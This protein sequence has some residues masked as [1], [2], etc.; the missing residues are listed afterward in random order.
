[1]YEL[2]KCSPI[3]QN[4]QMTSHAVAG[5]AVAFPVRLTSFIGRVSELQDVERALNRHRLVTLAGPGGAG[6]TRLAL[7]V[8]RGRASEQGWFVDLAP[9][10]GDSV[11]AA[12]AV[13]TDAPEAPGESP[14]DATVR[15]IGESSALLMLDNC[16]QVV[17]SCARAVDVLLRSC[18]KLTILATSR[19][20]LRVEGERVWRVP[21]LSL[22]ADG[23]SLD[24]DA[25]LLFLDR[26]RLTTDV[27]IRDSAVIHDICRRLDGMPLAIELA[28]ARASILP[29]ADVFAGLSDR[30]RLLEGGPRTADT[31]QQSLAASIRWSYRLLADDERTVL[32]RLAVYRAPF[33]AD[34]ARAVATG[35]GIDERE[36]LTLLGH[37]VEKSF[38]V[39]DERDHGASYRLL[40]TIREYAGSQLAKRPEDERATRTRHLRHLRETAERL[41][42]MIEEATPARDW[43]EQFQTELA[44]IKAAIGWAAETGNADDA[45]RIVGNM[46]WLWYL[47]A[48]ADD[49]Q[50]IEAALAI[51]G[52]APRWRAAA[53][54]AAAR[55]A[56]SALDPAAIRF[57]EEAIR[58]A[59]AADDPGTSALALTSLGWSYAY[60][61]PDQARPHLLKACELA[62]SAGDQRSLADA[63][64]ALT[65]TDWTDLRATRALAEEALAVATADRNQLTACHVQ[66]TLAHLGLMQ[67]R[68][69]DALEHATAALNTAE[70]VGER[71]IS[72]SARVRLAE[73]AVYRGDDDAAGEHT[74]A[75]ETLAKASGN[76]LLTGRAALIRGIRSY[77]NGDVE[78]ARTA[79]AE[80][81]PVISRH[82]GGLWAPPHAAQISDAALHAGDVPAAREHATQAATLA[83]HAGTDWGRSHAMLA[84]GRVDLHDGEIDE[85]TRSAHLALELAQRTDNTLTTI[86]ALEL[87]ATLAARRRSPA[88]ATRLLAAV[89]AERTRISYARFPVHRA[90]HQLL[91]HV[92]EDTLGAA[93]F[94]RVWAEGE[95]ISLTDAIA[96]AQSRRGSRRRPTTGWDALT[97][98][99]LRVVA[100]VGEGLSNRQIAERLFVTRDTVKGH[101]ASA[102]RKLGISNRTEL[103]TEATRRAPV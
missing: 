7:E 31:R 76:P 36:V 99:E 40:E 72:N 60:L 2:S 73:I 74:R 88:T 94:D 68:L 93:E 34:A 102:L 26:A 69:D 97:P 87:L 78:Q 59:V 20:P 51:P 22:P 45:L 9:V 6:K 42:P 92:L 38:V 19:E 67:G 81:L 85:A 86:D 30:F 15:R 82:V 57:G 17:E 14:I 89:S 1:M 65:Y 71:V 21:P 33:G 41:G 4:V 66:I 91:L 28:A 11:D 103:A 55:A 39:I 95:H 96:L 5:S 8:V 63:L 18:P 24:G 56:M 32:Q 27:A 64:I 37:L 75:I 10:D 79:L 84:K 12:L 47:R 90:D 80:G 3:S 77:A 48:R 98:A 101:V 23:E 44:D 58:A 62:R 50:L 29:V 52:G 53:L 54:S 16:D 49:R 35:G 70:A 46:T 83:A 100:L 25:V 13:A 43:P 61:T